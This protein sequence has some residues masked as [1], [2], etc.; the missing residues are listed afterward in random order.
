MTQLLAP[1]L[2]PR[3]PKIDLRTAPVEFVVNGVTVKHIFSSS[4]SVFVYRCCVLLI[5]WSVF[6][7][8]GPPPHWAKASSS[9]RLL[10][11]TQTH[12]SRWDSSG[13]VMSSSQGPTPDNTRQSQAT[14]F[15]NSGGIRTR[16]PSKQAAA[17]PRLRQRGHLDGLHL[18]ISGYVFFRVSHTAQRVPGL[19]FGSH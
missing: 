17:D 1:G 10:D 13:R 2:S 12:H 7:W 5:R 9:S 3:G 18:S 11:H 19:T 16:N 8:R 4:A 6:L 14:D 15:H